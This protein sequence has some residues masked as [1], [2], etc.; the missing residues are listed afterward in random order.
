MSFL[1]NFKAFFNLSTETPS[2]KVEKWG[3]KI[4]KAQKYNSPVS[5][6]VKKKKKVKV[7]KPVIKSKRV[8]YNF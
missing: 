4:E 7:K 8:Y 2:Q 1:K 5:K 6:K 3:E